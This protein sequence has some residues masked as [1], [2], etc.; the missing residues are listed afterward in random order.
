MPRYCTTVACERYCATA[1]QRYREIEGSATAQYSEV[2]ILA[3]MVGL[4]CVVY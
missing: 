3:P 1:R 2:H 4:A